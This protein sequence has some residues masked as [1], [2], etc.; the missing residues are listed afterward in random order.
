MSDQPIRNAPPRP[1]QIKKL[2]GPMAPPQPQS[3]GAPW[4]PPP[5]TK[6]EDTGLNMLNVADL[7]IKVIYL[8]GVLAGHEI[9]EIVKLP[10]TGV[11]DNII[12]FLKR[13]KFI[14]VRGSGG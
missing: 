1:P 12:E 3:L 6:L 13:E 4:T 7:V 8:G 14:E 11:L 5:L 9:A 10:F 2:T